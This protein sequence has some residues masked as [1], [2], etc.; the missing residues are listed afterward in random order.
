[1]SKRFHTT[2]IPPAEELLLWNVCVNG[3]HFLQAHNS[4]VDVVLWKFKTSPRVFCCGNAI[5][6]QD[7]FPSCNVGRAVLRALKLQD[8]WQ[9]SQSNAST[10]E[11]LQDKSHCSCCC[12]A[13]GANSPE[14]VGYER[15]DSNDFHKIPK[16]KRSGSYNVTTS[17][18]AK[19]KKTW[20][21]NIFKL[22]WLHQAMSYEIP[23]LLGAS[24]LSF[25][26]LDNP[27]HLRFVTMLWEV[28]VKHDI[29]WQKQP[30]KGSEISMTISIQYWLEM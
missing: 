13:H 4:L 17:S 12:K 10:D 1:M 14:V 18:K 30:T 21:S 8:S 5:W 11:D 24:R 28:V 27:Q 16:V 23:I 22:P 7:S 2:R 25:G 26:Q 20:Q 9:K 15:C 19:C 6:A 29:I 3:C